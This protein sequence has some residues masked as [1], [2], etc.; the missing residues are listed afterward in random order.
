MQSQSVRFFRSW[1][2]IKHVTTQLELLQ[3]QKT[4]WQSN[5]V[6]FFFVINETYLLK[7]CNNPTNVGN[8]IKLINPWHYPYFTTR[9]L[10]KLCKKKGTHM[11]QFALN[12]RYF[13]LKWGCFIFTD[14]KRSSRHYVVYG[15]IHEFSVKKWPLVMCTS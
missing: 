15:I 2:F 10:H 3:Q 6:Y 4:T 13:L 8:P 11:Y 14:L 1:L 9:P 5:N 7:L 12:F